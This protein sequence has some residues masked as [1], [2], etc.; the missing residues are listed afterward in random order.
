MNDCTDPTHYRVTPTLLGDCSLCV[1]E[2]RDALVLRLG[3]ARGLLSDML[4]ML[5]EMGATFPLW[6]A[7]IGGMQDP[8]GIHGL[9][10][11]TRDLLEPKGPTEVNP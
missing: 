1:R 11:R 3:E 4:P 9:T 5:E 7:P 6:I 10:A 8:H 2:E